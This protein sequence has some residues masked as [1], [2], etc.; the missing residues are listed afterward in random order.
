MSRL[1]KYSGFQWLH[2]AI[3]QPRLW[4]R[5]LPDNPTFILKVIFQ[6]LRVRSFPMCLHEHVCSRIKMKMDMTVFRWAVLVYPRR[7]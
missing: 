2:R 4:K 1:I 7:R 5:Y 6:L 3:K